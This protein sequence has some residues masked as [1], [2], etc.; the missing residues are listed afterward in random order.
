MDDDTK[1][2]WLRL[3]ERLAAASPEKFKEAREALAEIVDASEII[4]RF[5]NQ[6]FFRGRPRKHYRA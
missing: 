1:A 5:D 6:L 4:Q 3:G 2:E